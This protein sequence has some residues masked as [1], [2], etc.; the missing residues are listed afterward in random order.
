[1][2]DIATAMISTGRGPVESLTRLSA[3]PCSRT[4][5]DVLGKHPRK[6]ALINEADSQSDLA[7]GIGGVE[8]ELLGQFQA[9]MSKPPMRRASDR[10]PEGAVEI[11]D[12]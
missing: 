2:P 12:R 8:D 4:C 10:L 7:E 5:L 6:V 11:P 9:L 3:A 1:M